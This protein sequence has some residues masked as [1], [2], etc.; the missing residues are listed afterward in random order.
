MK[1]LLM[2]LML[3]GLGNGFRGF[4]GS[5]VGGSEVF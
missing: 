4:Y 2:V 5:E 3:E 1:A